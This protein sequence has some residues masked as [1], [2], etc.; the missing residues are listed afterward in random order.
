MSYIQ[1][2]Q[3]S[4]LIDFCAAASRK[5]FWCTLL[6][7][8]LQEVRCCRFSQQC[9]YANRWHMHSF[10]KERLQFALIDCCVISKKAS[11]TSLTDVCDHEHHSQQCCS[12]V[13]MQFLHLSHT[14]VFC[15]FSASGTLF[16]SPENSPRPQLSLQHSGF[17]QSST[18]GTNVWVWKEDL[19]TYVSVLCSE[20]HQT[21]KVYLMYVQ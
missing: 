1:F 19:I 4:N 14:E 17:V 12:H 5:T 6:S 18:E 11:L 3:F 8:F 15:P 16:L 2:K 10:L 9:Y 20:G 7:Y 21:L 13:L